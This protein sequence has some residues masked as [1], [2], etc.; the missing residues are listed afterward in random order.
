MK[1]KIQRVSDSAFVIN[2]TGS[3]IS[4]ETK[5]IKAFKFNKE[6][7]EGIIKRLKTLFKD[8]EFKLVQIKEK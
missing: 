4:A 6:M 5:K 3:V 1:Y 2:P 7:A 8:E